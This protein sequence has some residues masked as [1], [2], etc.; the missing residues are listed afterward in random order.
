MTTQVIALDLSITATGICD[1]HGQL[2]TTGG[3][4]KLGDH[5]LTLIHEA[6]EDVIGSPILGD[7][8][9]HLAVIEDLPTHGKGAGTTGMVQGI[10]RLAL[11][12]HGVPYAL[13]AAASLKMFATGKGNCDKA[14]MRMELYKR[15]G[16]DIADDNQVDAYWLWV[17]GNE[18]LGQRVVPMP[19][20]NCRALAKV[21]WPY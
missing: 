19:A 15:T 17:M 10:A 18:Y 11:R 12:D 14:T 5:R 2:T 7:S 6:I 4:A 21:K 16:M 20:A 1:Q 9:I 13:V 3:D 8:P